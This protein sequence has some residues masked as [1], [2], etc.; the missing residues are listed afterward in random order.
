MSD[1]IRPL[2]GLAVG[3]LVFAGL[4]LAT[5]PELWAAPGRVP[6]LLLLILAAGVPG[7]LLVAVLIPRRRRLDEER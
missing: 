7:L 6:Q 1:V 2:V 4:A 5:A 3:L